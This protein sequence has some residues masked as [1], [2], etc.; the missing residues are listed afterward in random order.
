MLS[1]LRYI[2]IYIS[3]HRHLR[4]F[5]RSWRMLKVCMLL[6]EYC[7]R[8]TACT[9]PSVPYIYVPCQCLVRSYPVASKIWNCTKVPGMRSLEFASPDFPC[10]WRRWQN[11]KN[12]ICTVTLHTGKVD[13][14]CTW[15][16][17][18]SYLIWNP[19]G[20]RPGRYD[21]RRFVPVASQPGAGYGVV[22]RS[23]NGPNS[24]DSFRMI[25]MILRNVRKI[26]MRSSDQNLFNF[27][28]SHII[29]AVVPPLDASLAQTEGSSH[30]CP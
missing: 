28:I 5:K 1:W 26:F 4:E 30:S 8:I 14:G 10:R 23:A 21:W 3:F 19:G 7:I 24:V 20:V 2:Y 11:W 16:V 18:W 12:M 17:I 6:Y 22:S 15:L 25:L 9:L 13:E 29:C 27:W